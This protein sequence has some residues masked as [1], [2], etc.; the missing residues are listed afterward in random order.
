MKLLI[1]ADI[2][3]P[4]SGGPATYCVALANELVKRGDEVKIVSLN[5]DGQHLSHIT[6][7]VSQRNKFLKY[8]Q[9]AYL[10]WKHGKGVDI[11][12]A[13]GPV[14][15]GL[16]AL[17]AAKLRRKKFVV[18]VVGDYAWEQGQVFGLIKDEIDDF[19]KKNYGGKIGR[20]KKME[21]DVVRCADLVI[22][23]SEYLWD[24]VVNY[25]LNREKKEKVKV[26]YNKVDVD[27][28]LLTEL[29]QCPKEAK[30]IITVGRLVPW[31]GIRALIEIMPDLKDHKLVIVGDGPE[32]KE[33]EMLIANLNLKDRVV[34]LGNISHSQVL[35]ELAKSG[36]FV[37][38]SRY[39]GLPHVVLEAWLVNCPVLASDIQ[40]HHELF[41][42]VY[43]MPDEL[44]FKSDE[45]EIMKK[46]IL[47]MTTDNETRKVILEHMR[48]SFSAKVSS[49]Y[50]LEH[51][52]SQTK[53]ILEK[54]CAS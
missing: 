16:P 38:N 40:A 44:L 21:R 43:Q 54:V 45:K 13:M 19:Q 17:I 22:V 24:L 9:Y 42:K 23:P 5:P 41:K 37:L 35:R 27:K 53:E 18:K 3:P 26:I 51:M 46:S 50:T 52:I 8:L 1:A 2:F 29:S 4:Q 7:H 32:R 48:R 15:A 49:E 11:I 25:W 10:L 14:N 28:E 12:Y 33:L 30:R 36:V 20:L 39:E 6:Y 47:T 34:M 31:K